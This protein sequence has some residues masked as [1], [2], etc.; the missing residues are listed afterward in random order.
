MTIRPGGFDHNAT[1]VRIARLGDPTSSD[2]RAARRAADDRAFMCISRKAARNH[3]KYYAPRRLSPLSLPQGRHI[4]GCLIMMTPRRFSLLLSALVVALLWTSASTDVSG[5]GRTGFYLTRNGYRTPLFG[6]SHVRDASGARSSCARLS[7]ERIEASRFGRRV[8]RAMEVSSPHV[9][10]TGAGATFDVTYT[11]PMGSGFNDSVDG[12][13]RR[14]ALEAAISAWTKVIQGTVPIKINAS[15]ED[16]D[17]GDDDPDTSV[18]AVASPVEFWLTDGKAIPSALEWQLKKRRSPDAGDADI[19]VLANTKADWDYAV[20]GVAARGKASFVYTLIHEIGHGLG[21]VD[22]FDIEIGEYANTVPFIYD[23]FLNR[24]SNARNRLTDR[25]GDQ[26]IEDMQ[27][28]DLFFDGPNAIDAS[29][30]SIR[31]LP[32][33]K[34]YAPDPYEPGSSISHVDQQTYADFKTGLM[35]P[36]DFG[37]GTDKIDILTLGILK[38]LGY[39][40]VPNAVTARTKN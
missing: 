20:N 7:P 4:V 35:T 9:V 13:N 10:V 5:A 25:T 32:M 19:E 31:P 11:D 17:D 34:L 12:A 37:S 15:M 3:A 21:F 1:H 40:L 29:R 2:V 23:T 18:L 26:A 24:T 28:G 38:D 27:S 16:I 22:S 36:V 33:I 30:R 8:S 14:R 6:M 39:A